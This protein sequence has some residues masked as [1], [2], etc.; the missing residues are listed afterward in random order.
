MAKLTDTGD[1]SPTI[2][3]LLREES[4]RLSLRTL[5]IPGK[6]YSFA[7]AAALCRRATQIKESVKWQ[8]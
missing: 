7:E 2:S 4:A 8:S 6:V 1:S 5:L 3:Q